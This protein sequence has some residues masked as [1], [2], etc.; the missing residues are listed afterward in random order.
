MKVFLQGTELVKTTLLMVAQH[1][2]QILIGKIACLESVKVNNEAN[3]KG[4]IDDVR[5]T[6][7]P[8]PPLKCRF[9]QS[10]A[11]I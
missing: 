8:Y 6:T 1:Y 9:V 7:V 3:Y 4:L 2:F 10:W 5:S 11:V